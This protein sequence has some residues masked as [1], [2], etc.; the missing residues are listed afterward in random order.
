MREEETS[1]LFPLEI[2]APPH[3][4]PLYF[5]H[6][7]MKSNFFTIVL[8]LLDNDLATIKATTL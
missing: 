3:T 2:F 6:L 1:K 8:I 7:E 5:E 4:N